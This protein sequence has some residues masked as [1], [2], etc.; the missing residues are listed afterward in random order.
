MNLSLM[1]ECRGRV[2]QALAALGAGANLDARREMQLHAALGTSLIL[3][4]G[5]AAPEVAAALT[6]A[7]EVADSLDDAEYQVRALWGLWSF[8]INSGQ[9]RV[10]LALA[11]R[12]STPSAR[13]HIEHMLAH[14]V[15][16]AHRSHIIRFHVDQRITARVYFARI[17]WLLGFPEQ[18][19]RAAKSGVEDAHAANHAMTLC[20]A[21]V[22]AA[23][24]ITLWMGDLVAAEHYGECCSTIRQDMRWRSGTPGATAIRDCSSSSAGMSPPDCVCCAPALTNS[25]KPGPTCGCSRFRV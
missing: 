9:G 19:M 8:H 21:L 3:T 4:K 24:P 16:L 7:L 12:F 2:E 20:S 17:L 5:A 1:E 15:P 14:Y 10:A 6:K 23:Y 11:Q 22:Q 13:R 18:A 25:V